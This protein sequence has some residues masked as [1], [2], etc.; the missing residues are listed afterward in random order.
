MPETVKRLEPT[1]GSARDESER[2]RSSAACSPRAGP[3]ILGN[4]RVHEPLV[5]PGQRLEQK[6]EPVT[7]E[8]IGNARSAGDLFVSAVVKT[9]AL[10]GERRDESECLMP[11]GAS[12]NDRL[13]RKSRA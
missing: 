12:C 3:I 1:T 4:L 2:R 6:V 11:G 8:Q 10:S 13:E 9:P 7:L 5:D